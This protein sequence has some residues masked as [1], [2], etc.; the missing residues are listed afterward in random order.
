[1]IYI[2]HRGNLFGP[3]PKEENS[4]KYVDEAILLGYNVEID[5]RCINEVLYLGH[6]EPQYEI[7]LD[8]L[9]A[10]KQFLWIHCKDIFAMNI[11]N[12]SDIDYNYFWHENDTVTLTSKKYIW[13][14]PGK[15][16]ILNSIAVM[17]EIYNDDISFC[18]GICSD[19]VSKYKGNE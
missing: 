5:L 16:P 9:Y 3:N 17:P 10:R 18:L 14:F 11:M 19:Y 6:D 8:W 2:A 1:M 15:Q 13:A 12:D 4:L 7:D